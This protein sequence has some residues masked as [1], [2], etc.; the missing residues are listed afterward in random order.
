M[1]MQPLYKVGSQRS[2]EQIFEANEGRLIHKWMHY[3]DI[4]ERHFKPFRYQSPRILEIGVSHGGSLDL[5]R[6]WF[7]PGAHITGVDIDPAFKLSQKGI[8]RYGSVTR[9]TRTS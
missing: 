8:S 3:F 2:L 7:G 4:Y 5:W 1:R 6:E 9:A